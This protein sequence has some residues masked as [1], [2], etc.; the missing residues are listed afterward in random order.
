[1]GPRWAEDCEGQLISANSPMSGRSRRPRRHAHAHYRPNQVVGAPPPAGLFPSC[2]HSWRRWLHGSP[3]ANADRFQCSSPALKAPP[4]P[5]PVTSTLQTDTARLWTCRAPRPE[6]NR[7]PAAASR[8]RSGWER[9]TQRL[10]SQTIFCSP[11]GIRLPTASFLT[12]TWKRWWSPPVPFRH[13]L[14]AV[15]PEQGLVGP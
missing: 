8:G 1:V 7:P 6:I 11:D 15:G 10:A 12:R 3:P 9:R 5:G 14:R 13:R 2:L 4:L